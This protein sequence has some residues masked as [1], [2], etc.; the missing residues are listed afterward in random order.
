MILFALIVMLALAAPVATVTA[1]SASLE[2]PAALADRVSPR[3]DL[4]TAEDALRRGDSLAALRALP[5]EIARLSVPDA[6][7]AL[8][9]QARAELGLGRTLDAIATVNRLRALHPD[10]AAP[11]EAALRQHLQTLDQRALQ[12]LERRSHQSDT[13]AWIEPRLDTRLREP[14]RPAISA[15]PEQRLN[16]PETIAVLL[17]LNGRYASASASILAGIEAAHAARSATPPVRLIVLDTGADDAVAVERYQQAVRERADRVLG[18]L[19]RTAISALARQPGLPVPVLALNAPDPETHHANPLFTFTLDPESEASQLATEALHAG[20]RTAWILAADTPLG[21]RLQ[22]AFARSF[23]QGN[24]RVAG[25]VPLA[26]SSVDVRHALSVLT[27]PN[28]RSQESMFFLAMAPEQARL[29]WPQLHELGQGRQA[30]WSTSHVFGG[31]TDPHRDTDL[32][33]LRFLDMPALLDGRVSAR[34]E[35]Q[36]ATVVWPRLFALG[37]DAFEVAMRLDS[38]YHRGE[39]YAGYS[40]TLHLQPDRRVHRAL[41][42]ARFV[43]GNPAPESDTYALRA[44]QPRHQPRSP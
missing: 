14:P 19:S 10:G 28:R 39:S 16:D 38:L 30:V 44:A 5:V 11:A 4:Q 21:Q 6:V 25:H 17:P 12:E 42:W 2:L 35:Q 8:S 24:G 33:G 18:P 36:N 40:G 23:E 15:R 34:I 26:P 20:Y 3:A 1:S 27:D 13:R 29:V 7:A 32:E 31:H 37:Y 9:I 43:A 22:R 41:T